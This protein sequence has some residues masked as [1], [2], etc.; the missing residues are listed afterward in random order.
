MAKIRRIKGA[1]VTTIIFVGL[2]LS[3]YSGVV[4]SMDR[5]SANMQ[6]TV[7][8]VQIGDLMR[9]DIDSKIVVNKESSKIV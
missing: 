9:V 7:E 4:L 6:K 1:L 8:N 5:C 3:S 2:P